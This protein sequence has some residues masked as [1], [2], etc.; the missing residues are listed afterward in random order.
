MIS[1]LWGFS[2]HEA[3]E[4]AEALASEDME[5]LRGL[6]RRSRAFIARSRRGFS[7]A[8]EAAFRP[9]PVPT[10]DVLRPV[11]E[12]P[13]RAAAARSAARSGGPGAARTGIQTAGSRPLPAPAGVF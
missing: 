6:L 11:R 10:I 9:A 12:M 2:E 7:H 8:V 13:D 3:C 1:S 4:Y 5:A